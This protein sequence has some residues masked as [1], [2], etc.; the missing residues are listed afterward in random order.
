MYPGF[1]HPVSP[2]EGF[3]QQ[4]RADVRADR[5]RPSTYGS[6]SHEVIRNTWIYQ[7]IN[8]K[9]DEAPTLTPT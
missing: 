4:G 9:R 6:Q 7:S 3:P 8:Q 1:N 2:Q 5:V